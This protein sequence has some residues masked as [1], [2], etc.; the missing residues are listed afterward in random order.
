MSWTEPVILAWML[1]RPVDDDAPFEFVTA[2][3]SLS[4]DRSRALRFADWDAAWEGR[5]ALGLKGV[6]AVV[7]DIAPNEPTDA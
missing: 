1:I 6:Y 4:R 2:D 7:P 3:G 5:L